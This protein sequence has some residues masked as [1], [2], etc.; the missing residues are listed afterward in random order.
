MP[1]QRLD[2]HKIYIVDDDDSVRRALSRLLRS[3][4]MNCESFASGEAL[5]DHLPDDACGCLIMDIRM[6]GLT[7]HD[8]QA[9]L[10]MR[11]TTIPVIALSAQ[12]DD[13]TRER[14][15]ALGAVTFFRKPVDDQALLDAIKWLLGKQEQRPR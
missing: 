7:G 5:L 9:R 2:S 4:G 13:E 3:A 12:D 14:A 10:R 8:V 6:P 1:S 11:G 15:R